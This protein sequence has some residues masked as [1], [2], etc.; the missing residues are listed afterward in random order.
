[1][2]KD[3]KQIKDLI[4]KTLQIR[5]S[6]YKEE[7]IKRRLLSRMRTTQ[8]AN[9]KE[10]MQYL[11]KNPPEWELLR[12]ALTINVTEFFRDKEVFEIL[13]KE[14][15]PEILSGNGRIRIW[16]AGCSS[17]EEPYSL[18]MILS[19]ITTKKGGA[20]ATIYATDIDEKIL[21]RAKDGIYEAKVVEK[22]P[23]ATI[24]R[25][26]TKLP[27]DQ[28]QVKQH[29]KDMIHFRKHDLMSGVPASRYVDIVTCRNVTIY[30]TE[31]QK[32]D[33]AR[34]I[35]AALNKN[36]YYVMGKT[37]Y[38]GREVEGLFSHYNALQKILKKNE[39]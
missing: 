8:S 3:L 21:K 6:N 36:G 24:R 19:E 31:Q 15:I 37:E 23:A 16:S 20:V 1:M 5:C 27:D 11:D 25:H 9:Y 28:Y 32:N 18:A 12:N 10:Y 17:G 26:F 13:R 2:D 39:V 14:L 38:L 22:L 35:H 30:F 4:E 29:L 33:L 7:Y 34:T